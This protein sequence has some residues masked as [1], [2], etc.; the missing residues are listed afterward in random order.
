M[1]KLK[2]SQKHTK[3]YTY[4]LN[5]FKHH[6]LI[7]RMNKKQI[8]SEMRI[9]PATFYRFLI[10][11]LEPIEDIPV[12]PYTTAATTLMQ[13]QNQYRNAVNQYNNATGKDKIRLLKLQNTLAM[14]ITR[15]KLASINRLKEFDKE[16]AELSKQLEVP[17]PNKRKSTKKTKV[18]AD[19]V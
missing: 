15:V 11:A 5:R 2:P 12:S 8:I 13:L 19:I 6:Y 14:D 16:Y 3:S 4:R 17:F 10:E 9:S 18:L 7:D 1:P